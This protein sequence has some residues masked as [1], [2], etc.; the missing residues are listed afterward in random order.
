[1]AISQKTSFLVTG[2]QGFIGRN[3]TDRLERE[4]H[5]VSKLDAAGENIDIKADITELE[6]LRKEIEKLRPDIVVHLAACVDS[7]KDYLTSKKALSVNILGTLNLLEILRTLKIRRF[8]F[9]STEEVYGVT[10]FPFHEEDKLEPQSPYAISKVSAEYFVQ[11]YHRLYKLPATLLRFSAIF[12]PHQNPAKF[13]PYCIL[14]ALKG[15]EIVLHSAGQ[16]RDFI[17][18]EDAIDAIYRACFSDKAN[19]EI[20]NFGGSKLHLVK[21]VAEQIVKYIGNPVKVVSKKDILFSNERHCVV[22][23]FSKAKKILKWSPSI[24]LEEG[25]KRT[26]D[27]YS[28]G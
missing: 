24:S 7:Q 25:L 1:M 2:S 22:S 9:M 17:F 27:W 16:K 23:D 20:I 15:Q 21:D 28:R 19:N 10:S 4:R 14:S 11:M 13:I 5:K 8:V 26:I 12:G 6:P 18:I 3:L